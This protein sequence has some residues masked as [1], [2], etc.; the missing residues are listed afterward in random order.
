MLDILEQV[1]DDIT[2]NPIALCV[3]VLLLT[4]CKQSYSLCHANS[5][6]YKVSYAGTQYGQND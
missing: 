5:N 3:M 1:G 4:I 6:D 2:D